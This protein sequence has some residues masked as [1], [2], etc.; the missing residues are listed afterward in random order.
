MNSRNVWAWVK[1]VVMEDTALWEHVQRDEE[2]YT[3]VLLAS[4]TWFLIDCNCLFIPKPHKFFK[5]MW[6]KWIKCNLALLSIIKKAWLTSELYV[7][8]LLPILY[9]Q[10]KMALEE[11][12]G[13]VFICGVNF[14]KVFDR[15]KLEHS[16]RVL[17]FIRSLKLTFLRGIQGIISIS[18][19]N[20]K[21]I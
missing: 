9:S 20:G 4:P 12:W 15:E 7:V 8:P 10:A 16:Y 19:E 18:M 6:L 11:K 3:C 5:I 14:F 2:I 1:A 17:N 21:L 13:S